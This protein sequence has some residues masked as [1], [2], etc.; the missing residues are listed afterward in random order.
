MKTLIFPFFC[1]RQS[2]SWELVMMIS[3]WGWPLS[4]R[5]PR[6]ARALECEIV[7][8]STACPAKGWN[9][10]ICFVFFETDW[11]PIATSFVLM[12]ITMSSIRIRPPMHQRRRAISSATNWSSPTRLRDWSSST[13]SWRFAFCLMT[14]S[15]L[16]TCLRS[17]ALLDYIGI[18]W[19]LAGL[20]PLHFLKFKQKKNLFF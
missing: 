7:M 14:S 5:R 19:A 10:A 6:C 16:I 18:T 20:C 13:F 3:N 2:L 8:S 12:R 4:H 9:L 15:K 1:D 11:T 17:R